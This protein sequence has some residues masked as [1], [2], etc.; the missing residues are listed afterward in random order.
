M[1][2]GKR[3]SAVLWNKIG[4]STQNGVSLLYVMLE[5]HHSGREPSKCFSCW[6][7]VF[8]CFCLREIPWMFRLEDLHVLCF[9]DEGCPYCVWVVVFIVSCLLCFVYFSCF[10]FPCVFTVRQWEVA[11]VSFPPHMYTRLKQSRIVLYL[12][13]L[14]VYPLIYLICIYSFIYS[15]IHFRSDHAILRQEVIFLA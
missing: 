6:S 3:P 13:H 9:T 11:V 4:V 7:D 2:V 10:L 1:W 8:L 14:F 15:L 5:I 12:V